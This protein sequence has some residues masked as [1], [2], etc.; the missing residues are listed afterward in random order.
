MK[1]LYTLFMIAL[2]GTSCGTIE[3][4][5]SFKNKRTPL[6]PI[7]Y[8][9]IRNY[10]V[11]TKLSYMEEANRQRAAFQAKVDELKEQYEKELK[12]YNQTPLIER[13][14]LGMKKPVLVLP[15]A[16]KLPYE[17]STEELSSKIAIEGLNKGT[18]NALQV[19]LDFKGFEVQDPKKNI[20]TKK[21]KKDEIEYV[22]TT[23]NYSVNVKHPVVV[24][25]EAP[26]GETFQRTVSKTASWKSIKGTASADTSKAF[27]NLLNKIDNEE[28]QIALTNTTH[29]NNLL[30]SEFG[31][32]DV[33]YSVT[34][35]TY[36]SN[37]K[38][39]Y[40]DLDQAMNLAEYG[41]KTVNENPNKAIEEM[42]KAFLI[43]QDAIKEYDQGYSKRMND[44]VAR[45]VLQ[46]I[47]VVS[48]FT[49][50]WEA[51]EKAVIRLDRLNPK[52]SE[53]RSFNHLK[54]LLKDLKARYKV[55]Q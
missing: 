18:E 40:S 35:Y 34:L 28:K 1:N 46:N 3:N 31:T 22:D 48:L 39:D 32:T 36:K 11:T 43:Y 24:N 23:F 55:Q 4:S 8:N 30:N 54:R 10:T 17:Y 26:S 25:V 21:R 20:I 45:G 9:G 15:R 5:V 37:K 6:N 2:L 38:K 33:R 42:N 44:K 47:I 41:L 29:V 53:L 12:E 49:Q 16:P 51:A 19:T 7:A 13:V 52:G 27:N 14:A 50:N